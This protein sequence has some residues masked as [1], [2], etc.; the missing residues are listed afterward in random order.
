MKMIID[1]RYRLLENMGSGPLGSVW[2]AMDLRSGAILRLKLFQ[3]LWGEESSGI[4]SAFGMWRRRCLRHPNLLSVYDFGRQDDGLYM[5]GEYF[6]NA[7]TLSEGGFAA[8]REA[9]VWELLARVCLGLDALHR[10]GMTHGALKAENILFLKT[11]QGLEVKLADHGFGAPSTAPWNLPLRHG[12]ESGN[13]S[14]RSGSFSPQDDLFSLGAVIYRMITGRDPFSSRQIEAMRGQG[15]R[16]FSPLYPRELDPGIPMALQNLCL[17]LLAP[18]AENHVQSAA[19]VLSQ[20]ERASGREFSPSAG[21]GL[22]NSIRHGGSVTRGDEL[23]RLMDQLPR[24]DVGA[25][26]TV[27]ILGGE[28]MGASELLS[29]FR[30]E[31]LGG[32]QHIFDY[33]CSPSQRDAFFALIKEYLGS[34]SAEELEKYQ[35]TEGISPRMRAYLF[36]ENEQEKG[37][38]EPGFPDDDFQSLSPAKVSK[39]SV[40][41][42]PPLM[43]DFDFAKRM[44]GELARIKPVVFVIRDIEHLHPHS[45]DFIN[46][47]APWVAQQPIL[48]LMSSSDLRQVKLIRHPVLIQLHMFSVSQ[49][50]AYAKSLAG[51]ELEEGFSQWLH[52]R[53]G[54]NPWMIREILASLAE[55]GDFS[56]GKS[57]AAQA[58]EG[59]ELPAEPLESIYA[60]MSRLSP[61]AYLNL[62]KLSIVQT[63]ISSGL[64]RHI[65]K[66]GD[67]ELYGLLS[68]AKFNEIL[69]KEGKQHYFT[70]VETKEKF[71]EQ[72]L[73]RMRKLVSLRVLQ[74]FEATKVEDLA[75]CRGLIEGARIAEDMASERRWLLRLYELFCQDH[76]Q[77]EAFNSIAE[78]LRLHLDRGLELPPAELASDLGK[79]HRMLEFTASLTET[80]LLLHNQDKL[81]NC[82]EKFGLLGT[83]VLFQGDTKTA[84]KHYERAEKLAATPGQKARARLWQGQIHA[85]LN[86]P[87]LKKSLAGLELESV[88]F[89]CQIKVATLMSAYDVYEDGHD[90]A[91]K[92]LEEFLAQQSPS[93][94]TDAMIELASLH[95]ALGEIYSIQ[96]D[97]AEAGEHFGIALNIWN[98]YNIRR[99]L[100]WIHNNLADLDLKQG[101]TATGLAHAEKA[102]AYAKDRGNRLAMGRA[103]LNQGEAKI[104]MGAFEEAETLLLEAQELIKEL[105]AEKYLVSIERNLALAKSKIIGF[106]HYYNFIAQR[107]PKLVQG[108]ISQINP[109]VKTYFYYLNEINNPKKLSNL[110]LGNTQIDYVQIHEQEFYHNALSLLAMSE[111]DHDTALKQLKLALRFAGQ[112]NNHYAMAVL[113]VLQATCHYGLGQLDRAAE[114]LRKAK[115]EIEQRNYLYWQLS[116]QI[117][118]LK[119]KLTDPSQGLR[120][121]LRQLNDCLARC[122]SLKYYQLEV[123]LRQMKIQLLSKIG[124]S[125]AAREEFRQYRQ[126]LET[127]T[128]DIDPQDRLNFLEVSQYH[129][130]DPA[131]FKTMPMASRQSSN[132]LRLNEI[133]FDT[134]NV[135]S[136]QRVKFL[137]GKGISQLIGPWSFVL[138]AWS[139]KLGAYQDFL[140][141]NAQLPLPGEFGEHIEEA[142]QTQSLQSFEHQGKHIVVLPLGT[143]SRRVG[144]LVL[145]DG[146]ELEYTPG[147][148]ELLDNMRAPLTAMLVRAWDYSEL[149]LRMEKMNR[150]IELSNELVNTK[151]LSELEQGMVSAAIELT[152]ATRGFL[153][154][155]DAE[156]NNFF[157]V[158]LDMNGQIMSTAFGVSKTALGICQSTQSELKSTNAPMDKRFEDSFSVQ[159]YGIQTIFCTPILEQD[160]SG[161]LYLDNAGESNREMYLNEEFTR[162]F[163]RLFQ[164]AIQNSLQYSELIQKSA[165]LSNLEQAKDYFTHIVS[166]EFNTPLFML[167]AALN[168][169]KQQEPEAKGKPWTQLEDAVRK[170]SITVADIQTMNRY[171][172]TEK[173]PKK[174]IDLEEILRQVHQQIEI[175][176]R[177]R[178]LHIRVELEKDLPL[179]WSSWS[180]LHLMIYNIVLNA[181]RFTNDNGIIT[182]GARRSALPQ[183]TIDGQETL[184]IF[185]KDNG[186]G[187]SQRRI[188]EVFQ[189]YYEL[190]DIYA[191]KSGLV[192]YRSSG[193]GL[194]LAVSKR[195]AELHGGRIEIQSKE[196]EGTSVFMIL[197]N[198]KGG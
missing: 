81:P 23:G 186:I 45:I 145:S 102:F 193:L 167:Q 191:H 70:F 66:L 62:Q 156:G 68:E 40:E 73:P 120:E 101:F 136:L 38:M 74:Y 60:S 57:P 158:Q 114:I 31:I 127:I 94:E 173:L 99:H 55:K 125:Q 32:E 178:R 25:G 64:I 21:G 121:L 107:E 197:P 93:Q 147:E 110:I 59:F 174:Q 13:L 169:L 51:W 112:I 77:Q 182:I 87:R 50:A 30:Y 190:G 135:N 26:K 146:G 168:R 100:A 154:K 19:E 24:Q 138:M 95:N 150:L 170:L 132:R 109:L 151:N 97:L 12:D 163:I 196:N 160:Y 9:E 161:Y 117:L 22:A 128:R 96:K 2:R 4:F 41:A 69:Q 63:P 82:F 137:I 131:L 141:Q 58:L 181:V 105:K 133:L 61:G 67:S 79:F 130:A 144:H 92:R 159:D 142:F 188:R 86:P 28:G 17:R 111:G 34:L 113:S 88:S 179:L 48:I 116:L 175:L 43:A 172:L 185:V 176:T 139:E 36:A 6:Q 52:R 104:K 103:L 198:K 149:Y 15:R 155:K 14:L 152:G 119:L 140:S 83:L 76:L 16:W 42:H 165:E 122:Q 54:G 78:V 71:F 90:L 148:L 53:S 171:N 39:L 7:L 98:S 166:H 124:A 35:K 10:Q 18:E 183:E 8:G 162:L 115:P 3:D 177:E 46:F 126:H 11:R 29:L 47:L 89:A 65:C 123:Q 108:N 20:I 184:V 85:R 80:D 153:I 157:Q 192:S 37:G 49:S 143:S 44:I 75:T 91:A 27:C 118:E 164:N 33:H 72:C 189:K 187:I 1:R 180:D 56:P 134:S 84:L 106:G 194:G 195:I 5:V 129:C